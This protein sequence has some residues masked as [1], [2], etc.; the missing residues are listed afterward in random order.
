MSEK[1]KEKWKEKM[2]GDEAATQM[3]C[4]AFEAAMDD[5]DRAGTPGLALREAALAHA[6]GCGR[7]AQWM[8][9]AEALDFSL[10]Q[11][12][13]HDASLQAPA[14]VEAALLQEMRRQRVLASKSKG[15]GQW[16]LAVL[17][18]AA[19]VLLAMGISLRHFPIGR[20]AA[21]TPA[22]GTAVQSNAAANAGGAG[23]AVEVAE[24]VESEGQDASAFVPLPYAT[25]PA[26][27]E[28]G[29]VVR[30]E[31]TRSALATMGLPVTDGG[32]LDSI[33]ADI[34]LSEDGVP[35]AI[36]LVPSASGGQ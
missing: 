31:L 18:T 23:P 25:D 16:R 26:T 21:E 7:C 20:G 5:L 3:D 4:G 27:L 10:R 22:K 12:A 1:A 19:A 14:R 9:D 30:V 34:M 15:Q 8:T 13:T 24:N 2:K 36:R 35:Q 32:S 11:I 28:D 17:A 33:P 29:T 6:E